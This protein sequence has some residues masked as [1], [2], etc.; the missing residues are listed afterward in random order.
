MGAA[1]GPEGVLAGPA[2][3]DDIDSWP[4][5][6]RLVLVLCCDAVKGVV[7]GVLPDRRLLLAGAQV[8][9]ALPGLLWVLVEC[10][11]L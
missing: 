4:V 2:L 6:G 5:A 3:L 10:S 11:S 8:L 7:L 9:T 1:H